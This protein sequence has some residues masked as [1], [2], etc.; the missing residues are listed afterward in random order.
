MTYPK[1][2]SR[3]NRQGGVKT[4]SDG[5]LFYS[6][7][8]YCWRFKIMQKKKWYVG[9]VAALVLALLSAGV[10]AEANGHLFLGQF[11]K[12]RIEVNGLC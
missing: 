5:S 2:L 11:T 9:A 3:S 7:L 1:N 6:I 4:P 8:L 10:Y 12:T